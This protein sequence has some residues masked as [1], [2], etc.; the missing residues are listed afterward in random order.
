MVR[1]TKLELSTEQKM[2]LFLVL[3][4]SQVNGRP[5]NGAAKLLATQFDVHITMISRIWRATKSKIDV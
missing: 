4:D 3:W 1:K 2:A 5:A